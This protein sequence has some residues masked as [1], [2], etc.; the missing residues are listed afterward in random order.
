M[1]I[2]IGVTCLLALAVLVVVP[3]AQN[4]PLRPLE[5]YV[6]DVEGGN[7]VLFATPNSESLLIDTGNSGTTRDVDRIMNAV[8]AAGLSSID[9][10]ITTHYHGD[11]VGGVVEL[12]AR[13][14]IRHFIDHGANVQ[15]NAA[16]DKILQ[17]YAEIYAKAGHAVAKPGD[18]IP[19]MGLDVRVLTSAGEAIKSNLPGGGRP[20]PLC[21]SF[22]PK[23]PDM[24]EN[25]QSVG[26]LITY[27]RFR[28]VHLGDLTWNKEFELMCPTNRIGTVDL[29]I[30]SH[31]GLNI[32]NSEVLVHAVRPRVAIMNNGIRKGGMPDTMKVLYSAPGLEDLWQI[33]FPLLG[34]QEYAVPGVF[35]ANPEQAP[36]VAVAPL[37]VPAPPPG[38]PP[39]PAPVH[40]GPANWIKVEAQPDGT[41][42]V[43]NSRNGFAKLY[44][45]RAN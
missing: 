34:G 14:P 44:A 35:I 12:A 40:D 18:K 16:V 20:N 2:R 29:F 4:R 28:V 27:G 26:T 30:V 13:I 42:T 17:Q 41:F 6:I 45:A 24:S 38:T 25:A 3:L 1:K 43:T 8:N 21:A 9:Y 32:S 33:H 11:H 10:L 39:T 23:D 36:T 22:K 5:V 31:H 19:L 7:A 37:V 15:P